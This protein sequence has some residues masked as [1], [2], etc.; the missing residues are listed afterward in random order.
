MKIK[1]LRILDKYLGYLIGVA[2]FVLKPLFRK[3]GVRGDQG[4]GKILIIKFWGM[5]SIV[6]AYDFFQLIRKNN[7]HAYLCALTLRQNRP[8]FEITGI[9]DEVVDLNIKNIFGFSLDFIKTIY[10]LNKK[11]FDISF[12]LEFT[13][14]FSSIV[15]C[16]INAKKRIGFQYDGIKRGD[17]FTD[18]LHFKEDAKLRISYLRTIDFIKINSQPTAEP[19][20]LSIEEKDKLLVEELLRKESLEDNSSL[21][22]ININASELCLLRRWPK[23]NFIVLAGRLIKNHSSHIIF[24]GSE[25]DSSYVDTAIKLFPVQERGNIHDFSGKVSL[26]QLIYLISKFKLFISNDSGPLH[27]AAYLKIPTISF[28][29]P[30]TPLIYGP[31]GK[32]DH[33]FYKNLKCSPC[34][35]VRNYKRARCNNNMCLKRITPDEVIDEIRR[36]NLL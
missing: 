34:L 11:S 10:L 28:F 19:V 7:P 33:V 18:T 35:R 31:T 30:E 8:I 26:I 4:P 16:L 23:E 3:T 22:G 14:R 12:D 9:F 20:R 32:T 25:E 15:S 21:V 24:V 6:L 17:F 1:Y 36:K 13:S 5:G 29:G 27:L 2:L